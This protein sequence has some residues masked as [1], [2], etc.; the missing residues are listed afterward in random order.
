MSQGEFLP[1]G[2][3]GVDEL[4]EGKGLPKGYNIFVLGSPGSG[5]TT[6]GL[7]FICEGVRKFDES[8]VYI[9]LDEDIP[10]VKI[11][12]SR[13]GLELD[14]FEKRNKLALVDA[15]PI[16]RL[17]RE[18]VVQEYKIGKREFTLESLL[19]IVRTQVKRTGA[20]RLVIDPLV[21][22]MSQFSDRVE[23][24]DAI[25]DLMEGTWE[26]GCTSLLISELHASGPERR[27]QFE[28]FLAEGVIL[29]RKRERGAGISL[30]FTVEKMRGLAHDHQPRPYKIQK[31]G[32]VVYPRE[33]VL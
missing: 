4:L 10:H 3:P 5:K 19:D 22:L 13:I 17:P 28:E 33:S 25:L 12:A 7:Q 9:S 20:K 18:L 15:S 23:R 11:N 6:F 26:T 27:Y 30:E 8:G 21:S 31:G 14:A 24:R 32:I 2:V 29:M 16:R 1:T